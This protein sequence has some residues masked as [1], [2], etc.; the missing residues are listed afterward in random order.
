LIIR[1][2]IHP[3]QKGI[4]VKTV[5]AVGVTRSKETFPPELRRSSTLFGVEEKS[6]R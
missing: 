3:S 6:A 2:Y 1:C 4:N 5:Q